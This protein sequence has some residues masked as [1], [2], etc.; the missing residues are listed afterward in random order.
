MDEVIALRKK[1]LVPW[2]LT[3]DFGRDLEDKSSGIGLEITR[4]YLMGVS[5]LLQRQ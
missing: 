2:E 5:H 4:D 1:Q 3:L